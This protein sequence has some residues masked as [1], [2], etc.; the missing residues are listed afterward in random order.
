M[1]AQSARSV[2]L[3]HDLSVL[4]LARGGN[5]GQPPSVSTRAAAH[6]PAAAP[7]P[8]PNPPT[9]TQRWARATIAACMAISMIVWLTACGGSDDPAVPPPAPPPSEGS[10]TIGAA[11]GFVDGP[12]GVRLGIPAARSTAASLFALPATVAARRRCPVASIC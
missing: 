11:G 5:D 8:S 12:D 9:T 1:K 3:G 2:S 4:S 6:V 10:A 7:A